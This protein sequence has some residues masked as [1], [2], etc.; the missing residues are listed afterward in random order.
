MSKELAN[1]N[2]SDIIRAYL[3]RLLSKD[4]TGQRFL[5]THAMTALK[6]TKT[7]KKTWPESFL[8]VLP[9]ENV[10]DLGSQPRGAL[11]PSRKLLLEAA[12]LLSATASRVNRE[13]VQ[14][15]D[16]LPFLSSKDLS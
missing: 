9:G 10:C 1:P 15:D 11:L 6:Q 2:T 3:S 13:A 14:F 12:A 7:T 8:M 4:N 5:P 16:E